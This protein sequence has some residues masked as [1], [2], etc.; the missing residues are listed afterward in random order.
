MPSEKIPYEL[1]KYNNMI[2]KYG[3]CGLRYISLTWLPHHLN[4]EKDSSSPASGCKGVGSRS[5]YY[6]PLLPCI[7]KV[8]F[9]DTLYEKIIYLPNKSPIIAF[10]ITRPAFTKKVTKLTFANG[11]LTEV[12]LNKPSELLAGLK[13]PTEIIK[14]VAGMPLELLQFRVNYAEEY[15]KLLQAQINE[16][17][18]RQQLM[19]LQ[20]Q[21]K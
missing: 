8:R 16:I 12:Y 13:I 11:V 4:F 5:V 17:N 14:A 20:Q 19:Q 6:R 9:F 2:K 10:D 3:E 1:I 21:G 15:N 18:N 7:L